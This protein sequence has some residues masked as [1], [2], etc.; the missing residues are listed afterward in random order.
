MILSI[1]IQISGCSQSCTIFNFVW[2]ASERQKKAIRRS[3]CG[4]L[5]FLLFLV[6]LNN[7]K[8][9]NRIR[10]S[11]R[12]ESQPN[13]DVFFS[14]TC[15]AKNTFQL[16]RR[17]GK[18]DCKTKWLETNQGRHITEKKK[19]NVQMLLL[20]VSHSLFRCV[21]NYNPTTTNYH[22]TNM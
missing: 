3:V 12:W 19:R 10:T 11:L 21:Q 7:N 1:V 13:N 6:I 4:S 14:I 22:K 16:S 9:E 18:H 5:L 20:W 8:M 2:L 17:Q 15:E